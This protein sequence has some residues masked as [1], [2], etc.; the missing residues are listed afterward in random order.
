MGQRFLD[1]L[2]DN[3]VNKRV[4]EKNFCWLGW[5][6]SQRDLR[7]LVGELNKTLTVINNFDFDPAYPKIH[8]F[9][10]DDFQYT[11]K[12]GLRLKHDACNQLHRYFEDLQGSAW[13]ISNYYKQANYETKY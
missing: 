3:L 8:P 12:N 13:E 10:T 7:Y 6:D 9:V 1:A 2:K 4:L 11:E 5:A